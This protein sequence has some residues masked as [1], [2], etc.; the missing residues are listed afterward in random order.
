MV[1]HSF[2]QNEYCSGIRGRSVSSGVWG[3]SC[4]L[5][6][7]IDWLEIGIGG[8]STLDGAGGRSRA[9]QDDP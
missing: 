4:S 7:C 9:G 2:R 5:G 3:C 8:I 1:V 6:C